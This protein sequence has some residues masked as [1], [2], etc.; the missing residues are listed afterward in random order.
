MQIVFCITEIT[1]LSHIT[2]SFLT[3]NIMNRDVGMQFVIRYAERTSTLHTSQSYQFLITHYLNRTVINFGRLPLLFRSTLRSIPS[4]APKLWSMWTALSSSKSLASSFSLFI[5][6]FVPSHKFN[7]KKRDSGFRLYF[8]DFAVIER[9]TVME[10]YSNYRW[11]L[12]SHKLIHLN[13]R[14]LYDW[15]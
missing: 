13:S 14:F 9:Q 7:L 1:Y 6:V 2:F 11:N 12:H 4:Y 3:S 8:P 5:Y 15:V 10:S